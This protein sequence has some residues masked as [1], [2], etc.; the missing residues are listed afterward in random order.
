M[1]PNEYDEFKRLL[2]DLC[3]STNR[4]FTNDLVRVYWEDLKHVPL[5]EVQR[6]AA[7]LRTKGTA[8]FTS[9]DL[10]PPPEERAPVVGVDNETMMTRLVDYSRARY[11]TQM[12]PWQHCRPGTF[13]YSGDRAAPRI[14]GYRVAADGDSPG[15]YISVTDLDLDPRDDRRPFADVAS[16]MPENFN[17]ADQVRDLLNRR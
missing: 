14:T 10:R 16:S 5:A 6:A 17:E 8:K 11:G 1:F 2:S 15:F 9:N 12:T 3:T 7:K 4:P 13:T